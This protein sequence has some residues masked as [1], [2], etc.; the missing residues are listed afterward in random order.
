MSILSAPQFLTMPAVGLDISSDSVRFIELE[1][2]RGRFKVSRFG[3]TSLLSGVVKGGVIL[4]SI[5]LSKVIADLAEEHHLTMANIALPEEQAFLAHIE[6]PRVPLRDVSTA[7]AVHL[8]EYVPIP[9]GEAIYDY[10]MTESDSENTTSVIVS[11]LPQKI[12]DQYLEIFRGTGITPKSFEFQSHAM[13]RA[14]FAKKDRGTY[15]GIDIGKDITNVFIVRDNIVF[16]SAILDIGGDT[17]TQAIVRKLGIPFV[18]AEALKARHGLIGGAEGGALRAAM[19]PALED[20][21][22]RILQHFAFWQSRNAAIAAIEK[23]VLTGGGANLKGISEYL[24]QGVRA[25]LVV[26]NP[27]VNVC[28]FSEYVPGISSHDSHGYTAAIGLALRNDPL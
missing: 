19:L 21:R 22:S 27:W 12:V 10:I 24:G 13:A 4:D 1:P 26:A 7:V 2:Y 9:P 14:V 16:F 18:E 23:V 17:L 11:V 25:P 3:G 5:A 8:E 20:L 6:F 15:M 28:D